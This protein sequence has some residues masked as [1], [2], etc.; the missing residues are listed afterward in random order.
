MDLGRNERRRD[1]E[2]EKV[3][4]DKEA[5]KLT[6][7]EYHVEAVLPESLRDTEHVWMSLGFSPNPQVVC[8]YYQVKV[9]K[10]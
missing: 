4:L 3:G 5:G 7:I 2:E 10:Q 9:K 8:L 1:K 6:W